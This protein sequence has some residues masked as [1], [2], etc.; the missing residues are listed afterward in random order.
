MSLGEHG[1]EHGD[2]ATQGMSFLSPPTGRQKRHTHSPATTPMSV[3]TSPRISSKRPRMSND[4]IEDEVHP[5]MVM[6]TPGSG[7]TAAKRLTSEIM[8]S[9][10]SQLLSVSPMSTNNDGGTAC[11]VDESWTSSSAPMSFGETVKSSTSL[12]KRTLSG[13]YG[14]TTGLLM[15]TAP[16]LAKSP[17]ESMMVS[18]HGGGG[19]PP[20]SPSDPSPIHDLRKAA[21]MRSRLL[22]VSSA[23]PPRATPSST[24]GNHLQRGFVH[25]RPP[26]HSLGVGTVDVGD[27]TESGERNVAK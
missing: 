23:L 8:A 12:L 10:L 19:L 22:N 5:S 3:G 16:Q 14:D 21:L 11:A 1:D 13:T 17:T 15:L 9:N 18:H 24:R 20:S 26:I 2:E 6:G 27:E 4:W 25:E 7:G